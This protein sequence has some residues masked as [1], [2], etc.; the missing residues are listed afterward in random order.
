MRK[1]DSSLAGLFIR[2]SFQ[3][4]VMAEY[5]PPI[6][7]I[8]QSDKYLQALAIDYLSVNPSTASH[9]VIRPDYHAL[10]AGIRTCRLRTR[11]ICE[12]A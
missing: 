1:P 11:L 3:L 9:A 10:R 4:G 7:E 8:R 2:I 12:L 6:R 5:K